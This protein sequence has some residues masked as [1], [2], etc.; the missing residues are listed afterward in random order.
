MYSGYIVLAVSVTKFVYV[1]LFVFFISTSFW[2]LE[3]N[4]VNGFIF[5]VNIY[6]NILLLEW[7]VCFI[8]KRMSFSFTHVMHMKSS[9]FFNVIN[10]FVI[11]NL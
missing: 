8:L 1:C 3:C 4:T 2:T 10:K 7:F 9:C 5:Q 11:V 6:I